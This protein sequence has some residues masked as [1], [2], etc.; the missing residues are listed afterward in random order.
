MDRSDRIYGHSK[1]T[2][3]VGPNPTNQPYSTLIQFQSFVELHLDL[4]FFDHCNP[5]QN[6]DVFPNHNQYDDLEIKTMFFFQVTSIS[7]WFKKG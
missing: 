3:G 1:T 5:P 6:F 7:P 4:K 2:L